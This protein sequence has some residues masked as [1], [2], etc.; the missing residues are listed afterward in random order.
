MSRAA[1]AAAPAHGCVILLT[2]HNLVTIAGADASQHEATKPSALGRAVD[3]LRP[4]GCELRTSD[5]PGFAW[6]Q[7]YR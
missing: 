6:S 7:K 3:S 1:V 4:L 2:G 5:F